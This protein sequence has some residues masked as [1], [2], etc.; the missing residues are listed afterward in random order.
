MPSE[1]INDLLRI[2]KEKIKLEKLLDTRKRTPPIKDWMVSTQLDE[3]ETDALLKFQIENVT[4]F[5]DNL[6]N[7]KT[8]IETLKDLLKKTL[9]VRISG[10]LTQPNGLKAS[11]S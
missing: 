4:Y 6:K 5:H 2:K 11:G 9:P 1:P 7:I 8:H 10:E 3:V